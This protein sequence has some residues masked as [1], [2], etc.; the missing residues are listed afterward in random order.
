MVMEMV[1]MTTKKQQ[2]SQKRRLWGSEY[3]NHTNFWA[4]D[5]EVVK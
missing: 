1:M 2:H 3:I 5:F 4:P